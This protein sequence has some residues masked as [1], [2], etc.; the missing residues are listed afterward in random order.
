M[1]PVGKGFFIWK[2]PNC[3]NGDA[4]AISETAY[5]AGL[6]HVLIKIANG[7]YDYNYDSASRNDL[8][9]PVA[10][11]LH[12]RG[13]KVWGWHYVFGDLPRDEAKAAIR[14]INKLPLDGY[15]IDAESEYKNKYTPCRIFMSELRNALPDFP[16]ALSS[17]RYPKYHMELPWNDFLKYCDYNMPQVYWEQSHN[18]DYQ[19]ERSLNEFKTAVQPF[20]TYI[21]TGAAYCAGGWCPTIEDIHLFLNK[22]VALNM[23]AVNFWSWDYCRLKLPHIWNAIA[24]YDW[25]NA[26]NPEKTILEQ[27]FIV[28]NNKNMDEISRIYANDAIHINALR[29][30]QGSDAIYG[31]YRSLVNSEYKDHTFKLVKVEGDPHTKQV[32]WQILKGDLVKETHE[33]TVGLLKDQ[34]I[35]HY[36]SLNI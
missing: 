6:T 34:I 19:L 16:T 18:P 23:S 2:I 8:V 27:L 17:F 5:Q 31:F 33:D 10:N 30:I 25:P 11:A 29:T 14:Q 9:A 35:Y 22:A 4:L 26:P 21:P 7:I 36:S 32:V 12:A 13:I 3:E 28:L 1:A 20:R 24:A 15:V